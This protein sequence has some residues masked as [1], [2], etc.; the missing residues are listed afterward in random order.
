M[1]KSDIRI[2]L[3]KE[4]TKAKKLRE[5]KLACDNEQSFEILKASEE[6]DKKVDF[7]KKISK[8]L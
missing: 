5:L 3:L 1:T 2:K 6:Q 8:I 4:V 7:L